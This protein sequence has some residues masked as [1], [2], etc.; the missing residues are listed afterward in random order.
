MKVKREE[1]KKIILENAKSKFFESVTL[2]EAYGRVLFEDVYA[3]YDIPEADK[4]AIDGIAFSADDV[5]SYPAVLKISAESKAG[6]K[7]RKEVKKKEAVFVMTGGLIPIGADTVVRIEDVEMRENEAVVKKAPKKW[8]LINLKGSEV[9]KGE[10]ILSRGEFLDY[11]KISLLAHL[12]YYELKVHSLPKI[13]ILVT[14]DEVK[15]PWEEGDKAGVKNVNFYILKGM[16]S[17]LSKITYYGRVKDDPEEMAQTVKKALEENDIV[18]SSGGASKGK[19][20]FVKDVALTLDL[21]VKFTVT[22]IRP[23]RP[24]IFAT[25]GEKLFFGLPGYPSALLVNACDFLLPAVRKIA[26]MREYENRTFK[27][28]AKENFKSKE[29]RVDFVRVKLEY[30]DGKIFAKSAGSQQTSNFL[31]TSFSDALVVIDDTRGS[32]K[33]GEIVEAVLM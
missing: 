28:F 13:G 21:E 27:V 10:K 16:L 24:L 12:G 2:N 6:E 4:S 3:K 11:K 22:N 26:G 18:L 31:S 19:Y 1:A 8:D 15:E 20:D 33:E 23:G 9:K 25:K 7:E 29:G 14:G 5:E 32:V 30:E 17:P